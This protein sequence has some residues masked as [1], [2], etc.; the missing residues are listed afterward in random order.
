MILGWM[1]LAVPED[2]VT[3]YHWRSKSLEQVRAMI[4]SGFVRWPKVRIT[5]LPALVEQWGL[6]R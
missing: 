4:P 2:K 1:I 3:D 5:P 6:K